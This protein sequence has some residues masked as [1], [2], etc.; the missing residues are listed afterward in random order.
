MFLSSCSL[1]LAVQVVPRLGAR[2]LTVSCCN[3]SSRKILDDIEISE[4]SPTKPKL[5]DSYKKLESWKTRG[6]LE[7]QLISSIVYFNPHSKLDLV[8]LS[9]PYGL[10]NYKS[11]DCPYS[12]QCFLKDISKELKLDGE[13]KIVKS[14]DRFSSGITLLSVKTETKDWIQKVLSSAKKSR[15]LSSSYL[16]LVN[17]HTG[18]KAT[19]TFRARMETLGRA[20]K[21]TFSKFHKELVILDG[22]SSSWKRTKSDERLCHADTQSVAK[23]SLVPLSLVS[24]APSSTKNHLLRIYL[25]TRCYPVLGDQ[26]FDYRVKTVLGQKVLKGP[27]LNI[28]N[29]TQLLTP[30]TRELFGLGKGETWRLPVF[31][32]HWRLFLPGVMGKGKDLT[33]FAPLPQHFKQ[34]LVETNI[35]FDFEEFV[36][37]DSIVTHEIIT[38]KK[39]KNSKKKSEIPSNQ[40]A[41]SSFS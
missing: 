34:T 29:R 6:S 19:E 5:A 32:H 25:A 36:K 14:V 12:L 7:Q 33:I 31:I 11:D 4:T 41:K 22:E 38:Q 30:A 13:L 40:L 21:E 26:L 18:F 27:E 20:D 28:K 9:K 3:Q 16:A 23:S 10:P 24:I 17:G 15:R 2:T 39:P 1:S 8:A 35:K 37:N